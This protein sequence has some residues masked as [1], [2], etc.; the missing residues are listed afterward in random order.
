MPNSG[1]V[2][3]N[4]KIRFEVDGIVERADII[5]ALFG[6]TEGLLGP[7]MNLN[8]LQRTSKVGRIEVTLEVK[9]N[10]STGEVIIPMSAD[11][12]TTALI[13]AA[14]ETIDKVGPF[15]ARFTLDVIEDVREL[16]KKM[17]VERAKKIVQEWATKTMSESEEMLKDIYDAVK[18][19]KLTTY[20]KEHLA[21]GAG[22]FDS[23]WIILVEGRADVINLLRAGYDNAIAIEGAKISDAVMKLSREKGYVVAFLDGDRAAD[24]ILRELQNTVRIDKVVRAPQGKEVED[25]TPLEIQELLKDVE[26]PQ[27]QEVR[28]KVRERD[29]ERDRD[30]DREREDAGGGTRYRERAAREGGGSSR[31]VVVEEVAIDEALAGK[32]REAFSSIN[33]TL[34]AVA[35]SADMQQRFRV[36]VSEVVQKLQEEKDVRYLILDGIITQRLLDACS[37]AGVEYVIGHRMADIKNPYSIKTITFN[38]LRLT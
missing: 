27:Q 14:V 1:V 19:A 22:V 24:L 30:R 28:S 10:K 32:I 25:L 4:V 26:P 6:Q 29:R 35:L 7:E 17:I 23:D 8:E 20:G 34:E 36:P 2:K 18:P 37:K 38:Q 3:Y 21:C 15:N 33:E 12:S 13:A 5:G 9:G 31:E 16:K 11:I